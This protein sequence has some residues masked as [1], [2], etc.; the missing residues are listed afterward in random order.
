MPGGELVFL[1]YDS[2]AGAF[3]TCLDFAVR[4]AGAGAC[5]ADLLL[6]KAERDG[7]T[8]VEVS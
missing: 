2:A 1:Y 3:A 8:G 7:S 6:F 4:A 5:I